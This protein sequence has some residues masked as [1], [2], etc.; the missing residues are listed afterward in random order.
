MTAPAGANIP[1]GMRTLTTGSGTTSLPAGGGERAARRMRARAMASVA[2]AGLVLVA[3]GCG[4]GADDRALQLPSPDQTTTTLV[5]GTVSPETA[6]DATFVLSSTAFAQDG[7]IPDRYTCRG[8]GS[9]PPLAWD[10][11]PA[12]TGELALVVRG[13]DLSRTVHWVM[14][15]IDGRTRELVEGER[16]V[17]AVELANEVTGTPGWGPP[18][19]TAAGVHR[20]EF[21]LYAF[22]APVRV[23]PDS[24]GEQAALLIEGAPR[25]GTTSLTAT[26]TV[27]P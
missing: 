26:V 11:V 4:I 7:G 25:L 21:T 12:G 27:G 6:V 3:A 5:R 9:T 19:P 24:T 15:G 20:Y 17:S 13:T 1:S 8:A 14:T 18:C 23:P 2:A 10:N 16:P 22:P